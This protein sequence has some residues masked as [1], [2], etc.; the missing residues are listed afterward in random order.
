MPQ[1]FKNAWRWLVGA[2]A[3][4]MLIASISPAAN[5]QQSVPD[6]GLITVCVGTAGKV[7]GV[8]IN[9]PKRDFQLTWNIPGPT[10][11]T[12]V[13]GATGPA[14]PVGL[15]G[16]TGTQGDVGPVGPTGPMGPVGFTGPEGAQGI[17]G[18]AGPT[19]NVG[20]VG[21]TGASG[22]R[23]V[24][25]PTGTPSFGPGDDVVIL[26]GG[27]LGGTI[28]DGAQITLDGTTGDMGLPTMPLYFGPGNGAA[29]KGVSTFPPQPNANP[30]TSV[31]VP[32]PGGTAFN[33]WVAISPP[34]SGAVG[35]EYT[36]VICNEADCN[37]TTNPFC[38]I[39]NDIGPPPVNNSVC[40][41]A[42][43]GGAASLDFLPGDTLSIQAFNSETGSVEN[44]VVVS[45]S[46]DYAIDSADAF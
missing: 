20:F 2:S 32:T 46:M 34:S 44:P 1:S 43:S 11:P 6:T 13:Q 42:T 12:G 14:G 4:A 24:Q 21:P 26:S 30:Q 15:A 27:A 25:G 17:T 29:G 38:K 7:D 9:C 19:G 22:V 39:E 40:S 3:A 23:G 28:G 33:M 10:G 16:F 31:E 41:T 36:F 8:N 37:V 18:P 35:A 5:A 45:W